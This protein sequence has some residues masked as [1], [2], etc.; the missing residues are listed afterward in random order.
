MLKEEAIK[1]VGTYD[2]EVPSY[3][4]LAFTSLGWTISYL[5]P[6]YYQEIEGIAEVLEKDVSFI[7]LMNYL[8]EL[9]SYC[10]STIVRTKEGKII[11]E[12]N[13]D[14]AFPELMR[15][16]TYNAIFVKDG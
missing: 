6:E 2:Q 13:L 7:L 3:M 4:K 11:L 8:Y 5:H 10:T 12:R 16:T 1:L 9:S 15:N 14:F